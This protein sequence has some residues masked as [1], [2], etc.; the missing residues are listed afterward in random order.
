MEA[1]AP[2]SLSVNMERL[3]LEDF[4]TASIRSAAPS[5]SKYA[6]SGVART[7]GLALRRRAEAGACAAVPA[8]PESPRGRNH[9]CKKP[10]VS[11]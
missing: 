2:P 11:V 8:K 10:R 3:S 1:E 9:L 4:D 5:Y 6:R 7:E